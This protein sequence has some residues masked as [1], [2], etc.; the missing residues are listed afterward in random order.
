MRVEVRKKGNHAD[1]ERET[2]ID[3][4]KKGKN[5]KKKGETRVQRNEAWEMQLVGERQR[6]G[7]EE[8]EQREIRA[9]RG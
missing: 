5:N 3:G 1:G 9:L 2:T 7:G 4:R 6:R 8:R